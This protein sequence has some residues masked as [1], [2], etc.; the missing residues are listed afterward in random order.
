MEEIIKYENVSKK[1]L[2][3]EIAGLRDQWI[4]IAKDL[5]SV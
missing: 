4:L 3:D 5:K 1:V 2:E